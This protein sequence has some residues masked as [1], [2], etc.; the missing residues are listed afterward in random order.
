MFVD[1]L[2]NTV[3]EVLDFENLLI[4][5]AVLIACFIVANNRN[6]K[7]KL[8][9][10]PKPPPEKREFEI[11]ELKK[12]NGRWGYEVY[13]SCKGIVYHVDPMHYGSGASYSVFAGKDISRHLGKMQISDQEANQEWDTLT[14]KESKIL[15]DWEA[16]FKRKYD[17]RGWLKAPF[18]PPMSKDELDKIPQPQKGGDDPITFFN[19]K[20]DDKTD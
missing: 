14:E 4:I 19:K 6:T 12:Y 15:N 20:D 7:P 18:V 10:P 9:G 1:A 17:I 3:S 11:R 8:V 16:M 2:F 5:A 13:L